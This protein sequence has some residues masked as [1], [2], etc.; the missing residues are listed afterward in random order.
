MTGAMAERR[1]WR[2]RFAAPLVAVAAMLPVLGP[3]VAPHH[4]APVRS[5]A[6]QA[7][8]S[9]PELPVGAAEHD[10][11][12][13]AGSAVALVAFLDAAPLDAAGTP[14]PAER[15]QVSYDAPG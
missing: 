13:L 6:E 5:A 14:C 1:S 8:R 4:A 3:E 15:L 12:G 11:G 10:A 7:Y 2:A 9:L